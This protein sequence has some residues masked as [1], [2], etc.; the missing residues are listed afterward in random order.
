VRVGSASVSL[1]VPP[2]TPL[3]GYADRTQTATGTLDPVEVCCVVITA[4]GVTFALVVADLVCVNDDLVEAVAASVRARVLAPE[5]HVW[6]L[7]THTHSGPDQ[8]CGVGERATPNSW[9]TAVPEAAGD[10]AAAAVATS[11]EATLAV[12]TG[13][14]RD[15]GSVRSE[16]WSRPEVPVDLI[17]VTDDGG[18]L[19]G[20]LAV[21]PIHPTVLPATSSLVSGDLAAGIRRSLAGRLA[22]AG[23]APWVVVATGCA[24]DIS[25]RITRREQTPAECARLAGLA[26]DRL[27]ELVTTPPVRSVAGA[28]RVSVATRTLRLAARRD[29]PGESAVGPAGL[30]GVPQRIAH[31]LAQGVAVAGERAARLPD[32]VVPVTVSA[33]RI[34]PLSIAAI[35][36]EPYLAVRDMLPAAAVVFGYANG[37]AGYLPDAAGFGHVTYESL[38]S[39]FRPEAAESVVAALEQLFTTLNSEAYT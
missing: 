10:V 25:T 38:S 28:A 23:S 19:Q 33:A 31:T 3:G 26:A 24:G 21:V 8:N 30:T 2:G 16:P 17:T 13:M 27:A 6:V 12:R 39:P 15:V 35:G 5:V 4:D 36:A 32:A 7:A 20:V 29:E 22:D 1:D 18:R 37:Y 9:L 11:V 14:L 34:G